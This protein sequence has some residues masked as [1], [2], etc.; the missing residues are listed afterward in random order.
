MRALRKTIKKYE[1]NL[2]W[3]LEAD[4]GKSEEEAYYTEIS[5][6]YDEINTAIKH[7]PRWAEISPVKGGGLA[8]YPGHLASYTEPLGLVLII[9]PWNY[10]CPVA[11][12]HLVEEVLIVP[13]RAITT[14]GDKNYVTVKQEDGTGLKQEV[15]LGF[16]DGS[17]YEVVSGLE[18]GDIV[19]IESQVNRS[20]DSNTAQSAQNG[21]I[22]TMPEGETMSDTV[23]YTHLDVYKR[24][25][26]AC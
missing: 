22:G 7:L 16:T 4:L 14:E 13:K 15:T 12:T 10:P 1:E 23:S 26:P 8:Q 25:P 20:A 2:I 17:S 24:Q 21:L 11:Y 18:E 6:V 19:L 9:V 3:A 5:M